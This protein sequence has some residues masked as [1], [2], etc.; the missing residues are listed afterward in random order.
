MGVVGGFDVSLNHSDA[1]FIHAINAL[2][3]SMSMF[4]CEINTHT[5]S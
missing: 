2:M 3:C 1:C 4:M 5:S